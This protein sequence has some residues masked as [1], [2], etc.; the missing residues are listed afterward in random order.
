MA[1]S[2]VA[3]TL[4]GQTRHYSDIDGLNRAIRRRQDVIVSS[5]PEHDPPPTARDA[6]A[7]DDWRRRMGISGER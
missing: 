1:T 3:L 2:Y 7:W 4:A 5:H 6:Q